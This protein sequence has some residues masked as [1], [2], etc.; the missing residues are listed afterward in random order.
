MKEK[1]LKI[2]TYINGVLFRTVFLFS[3]LIGLQM[4]FQ[5]EIIKIK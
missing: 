3:I 5:F 2:L 1:F 4:I